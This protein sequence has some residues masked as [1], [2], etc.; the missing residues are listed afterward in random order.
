MERSDII[1]SV[2]EPPEWISGLSLVPKGKSDF[3]LVLNMKGPNQA[4][5]RAYHHLP[6]MDEMRVRLQGARAFTELDIKS[7][8]HH[9]LLDE[10]SRALTTFQTESGM[11]RFKRLMFGVNCSPEIFQRVM[12]TVLAGIDG[13]V[14]FIDDILIFGSRID[15]LRARTAKVLAALKANNLTLN[16]EKCEYE[17]AEVKFLGHNLSAA[18]FS[19]DASKS[20]DV[21]AFNK[22]GNIGDMRSFLGLASY[23]SE[24]IR[25]FAELVHPL[26]EMVKKKPFRWTP[27]GEEAFVKVKE[28]I[29]NC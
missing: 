2:L 5:L 15:E 13:V 10:E 6:T 12:E 29:A 4:I 9:L 8:F 20:G 11:K 3:R 24:Y 7:A 16:P 25:D 27:E 18:G 26:R 28:E 23:L 22:P 17:R 19:I 21:R 14:V 1:E